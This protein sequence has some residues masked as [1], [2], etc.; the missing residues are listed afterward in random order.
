MNDSILRPVNLSYASSSRLY[1][2]VRFF[3]SRY[4]CVDGL[5]RS[6][7]TRALGQS[8][9]RI[10]LN[11]RELTLVLLLSGSPSTKDKSNSISSGLNLP[12]LK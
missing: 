12:S 11:H 10:R 7:S 3:Q 9:S 5:L 1:V 8:I 2:S 6:V 4:L